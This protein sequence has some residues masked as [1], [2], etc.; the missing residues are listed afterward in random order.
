MK[1]HRQKNYWEPTFNPSVS[2]LSN[3]F[4]WENINSNNGPNECICESFNIK[5]IGKN[6]IIDKVFKTC[7]FNGNFGFDRTFSF[8][9]CNFINCHFGWSTWK[10]IKFQKCSFK[11]CAFGMTIFER[12]QFIDCEFN[13]IYMSSNETVF[14]KCL[15]NPQKVIHNIKTNL[16]HPEILKEKGTSE[17][18]QR[19]RLSSTKAKIAKNLLLSL[20]EF[21]EDDMFILSI[22]IFSNQYNFSRIVEA[23]HYIRKGSWKQKGRYLFS[24]PSRILEYILIRCFGWLNRWGYGIGRIT[25]IGLI[26]WIIFSSIYFIQSNQLGS[27][28]I[29]AIDILTLAGYS[30]YNLQPLDI[31]SKIL[32]IT[33]LILGISWFSLFFP[34]IFARTTNRFK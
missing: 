19:Y 26:L 14:N 1:S 17:E 27:S 28:I 6:K 3:I 33:N 30:K 22:K 12:C 18:Y 7:D 4:S 23:I 15:I 10:N 25:V 8:K 9:D 31:P 32:H 2:P 13:N 24:L 11:D 29:K 5:D 21:G 16:E 20:K 34:T